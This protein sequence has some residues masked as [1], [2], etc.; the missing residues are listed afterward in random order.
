M[1]GDQV[2]S[3]D[4]EFG[5]DLYLTYKFDNITQH[6]VAKS[7]RIIPLVALQRPPRVLLAD[8]GAEDQTTPLNW[9]PYVG[10]IDNQMNVYLNGGA[11]PLFVP[12]FVPLQPQVAPAA[13]PAQP[14]DDAQ[15]PGDDA[16][17][18]DDDADDVMPAAPAAVNP[19]V[20]QLLGEKIGLCGIRQYNMAMVNR[21]VLYYDITGERSVFR[22]IN[23]IAND[24]VVKVIYGTDIGYVTPQR[25][26]RH[27]QDLPRGWS[28]VFRNTTNYRF[29]YGVYGAQDIEYMSEEN[30]EYNV[31]PIIVHL[32]DGE[33]LLLL[34]STKV[35]D[36]D[37]E[38]IVMEQNMQIFE[39]LIDFSGDN[40]RALFDHV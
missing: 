2:D 11:A 25:T 7:N 17:Q 10:T 23:T 15:Q 38:I 14:G 37:D 19:R 35:I 4:D 9:D 40:Y 1:E 8:G 36:A 29:T 33:R 31:A 27:E 20:L 24:T 12:R 22:A 39:N 5:D 18:A 34:V 13:P 28:V 6:V 21:P 32:P 26:S 16:P 3:S 30:L